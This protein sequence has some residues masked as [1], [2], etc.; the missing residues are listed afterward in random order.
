[1]KSINRV[2]IYAFGIILFLVTLLGNV[3]ISDELGQQVSAESGA[4]PIS[5]KNITAENKTEI[6]NNWTREK[7]NALLDVGKYQEAI[8]Y[9]DKALA[10]SPNSTQDHKINP[11]NPQTSLIGYHQAAE[12]HVGKRYLPT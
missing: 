1:M 2:V 4:L 6:N 9:Y 5:D 3:S 11:P 7:G 12:E 8:T 10:M